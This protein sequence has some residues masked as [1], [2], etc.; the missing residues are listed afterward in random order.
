M[1]GMSVEIEAKMKVDDLGVVRDRLKA[2]G[3]TPIGEYLERNVFFDTEDRSLLTADQGLRVRLA[4]DNVSGNHVCTITF[5]GPR[6]HGV[7]KSREETEVTIG[8]FDEANALLKCLGYAA[9]LSFEKRRQSWSIG[10]CRVELDELPHLGPYVEIEGK[11]EETV[12]KV[13]EM[14]QLADRPLIKTSYIA[15]LLTHLQ[16]HGQNTRDVVFDSPMPTRRVGGAA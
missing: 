1:L 8:N 11:R 10:G 6:L 5:K 4:K 16:E 14:L 3:A 15:L 9:V 12:L 13:R 7:L 2:V